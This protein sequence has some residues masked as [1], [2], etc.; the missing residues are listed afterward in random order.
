MIRIV[1]FMKILFFVII[2]SLGISTSASANMKATGGGEVLILDLTVSERMS[3]GKLDSCE[4]TYL[5]AYAD[6]IY[7]NGAITFLRGSM[8]FAVFADAPNKPPGILLK[9]TAFDLDN[10]KHNLAPL[11]YAYL[12]SQGIS[13]AGKESGV[14]EAED[15]GLVVGYDAMSNPSLDLMNP[16]DIN[17][18]RKN[19]RSD[20]SVPVN[21][22]AYNPSTVNQFAN[23]VMKALNALGEKLK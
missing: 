14:F 15:G 18:L 2:L 8:N 6:Y 13:Y 17:I 19:G 3:R 23:C 4:Y 1:V 22:M 12:S 5:L 11:D 10:D 7:R 20:V 21:F 16:L 9:V